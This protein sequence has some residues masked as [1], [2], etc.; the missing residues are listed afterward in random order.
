MKT[1]LRIFLCTVLFNAPFPHAAF[2][3]DRNILTYLPVACEF[4]GWDIEDSARIFAGEE[5]FTLIDG[6]ADI[7]LEYGFQQV[8]AVKYRNNLENS[9]KLEIY[10]MSDAPAAYGM[11]SLVAGNQGKKVHVGNEGRIYDYYLMFWKNKFLIFL[12]GDDTTDEIKSGILAM[13]LSIDQHLGASGDKPALAACLPNDGLRSCTFIRGNIGLS[14]FY[15]FDNKNIFR[16]KEGIIG[17]YPTH[18]LFIFQYNSD[19]ESKE[20]YFEVQG[21]LRTS[22]R[23]SDFEEHGKYIT[24]ID[25]KG[26]QLCLTY[27]KNLIVTALC[28]SNNNAMSICNDLIH[29]LRD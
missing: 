5:L 7:Y 21:I 12:T 20:R 3:Q 13:S 25:K 10:E 19:N 1:L 29:S 4:G 11:F 6:G 15:T 17:I 22:N 9:I 24:M 14:S 18:H 26:N 16:V 28:Q 8:A 2:S 27:F 23:Y